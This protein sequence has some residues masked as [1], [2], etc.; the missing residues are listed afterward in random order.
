MAHSSANA[1][2]VATALSRGAFEFQGQKCSAASRAYIPKN[3][4]NAVQKH[5]LKDIES[6]K[7]GTP[8]DF[9]NFIN[10]VIDKRSFDKISYFIAQARKSK[11]AKIIAGGKCDKSKGYFIEPTVIVTTDPHYDSMEKEICLL[12][13]SPSPRD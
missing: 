12:Y 10:A 8:E 5:L 11:K 4:W 2:Q 3:L 1:K 6:M 7:M 13:T 9:S